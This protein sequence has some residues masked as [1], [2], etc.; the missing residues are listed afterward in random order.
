[1]RAALA[2]LFALIP[3]AGAHSAQTASPAAL[4]Q[5][6]VDAQ[7]RGDYPGAIEAYRRLLQQQPNSFEAEANLG[8]ALA[9]IG[10]L[11]EA[12]TA[13]RAALKLDPASAAVRANLGLAFYKKGDVASAADEFARILHGD[14]QNLRIAI[15]LG[16]SY[17]R[18]EHPEKAVAVLAPFAASYP[19]DLDLAYALGSALVASGNLHDGLPLVEKAAQGKQSAEAWFLAGSMRLKNNEFKVAREDLKQC[20]QLDPSYPRGLTLLGISSEETGD[21]TAAEAELRKALTLNAEDFQAN[22]HLGGVLYSRRD[23]DAARPYIEKAHALDPS[24]SF[25]SY[26]LALLEK[27]SGDFTDAVS[28]LE[29]IVKSDPNWLQPHV[30]LA[31]LYYKLHRAAEG[32]KERQIVDHLSAQE[33]QS[34]PPRPD[35]LAH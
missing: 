31:A 2:L 3:L 6:G 11:D 22:L 18:A 10:R 13:Y 21:A 26:E 7:Q 5:Q 35:P 23:L 28:D 34:E 8:A 12:I 4:F 20:V 15:L 25:A 30:E 1:M 16:D 24:S 14:P 9:H 29:K 19:N 33:Q 32:L 27:A 17:S